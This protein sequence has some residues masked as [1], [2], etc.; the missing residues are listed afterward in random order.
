MKVWR[1]AVDSNGFRSRSPEVS[2]LEGFS[3]AVFGFCLTL[4]VVALQVPQ[5]F[6][7]LVQNLRGFAAFGFS[8]AMLYYVWN[9]H[10][11]YC[12]RFGLE[13]GTVRTLTGFLLFIVALYVYPL[14]FLSTL[15]FGSLVG[16]DPK[17]GLKIEPNQIP[18][19]FKIYGVGFALIFALLAFMY[20]H[21]YRWRDALEMDEI[22]QFAT[23]SEIGMMRLMSAVGLLSVAVASITPLNYS[24]AAGY[25]YFIIGPAASFYGGYSGRRIR[26]MLEAREAKVKLASIEDEPGTS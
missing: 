10:F 16:L 6:N 7:E 8:F 26:L 1:P 21:A 9:L 2:R 17:N 11:L 24:G 23:R 13:D 4:L 20:Q 18:T 3:D 5:S 19:L 22:E 15:F 25:V 12:R 14:K